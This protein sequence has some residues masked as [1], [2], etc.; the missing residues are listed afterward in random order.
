VS[1]ALATGLALWWAAGAPLPAAPDPAK[2]GDLVV[3]EVR[4]IEG[5][6]AVHVAGS[7]SSVPL[8][9]QVTDEAGRPVAGATVSLR[10][11]SSGPTGFFASGLST[12]ILTTS[13]DGKVSARGIRWGPATGPLELRITAVKGGVRAGVVSAQYVAPRGEAGRAGAA[14]R[15]PSISRP[16]GK[17]L[18]IALVAAG[19]AAGGLVLGLSNQPAPG[20]APVTAP[21]A[22]QL[23]GVQVGIPTITIGNP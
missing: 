7:R 14:Q 8:T 10:L 16:R 23:P 5:D 18:A 6:G 15:G 11:P 12:E 3:L 2:T 17:W 4:V 13:G 9:V 1:K 20:S 21:G 19:A 22:S